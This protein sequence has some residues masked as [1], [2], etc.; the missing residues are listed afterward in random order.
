MRS[1]PIDRALTLLL[2]MAT[3]RLPALRESWRN[4]VHWDVI[5]RI[6]RFEVAYAETPVSIMVAEQ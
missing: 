5:H 1:Q 3:S 6:P 4:L 2:E